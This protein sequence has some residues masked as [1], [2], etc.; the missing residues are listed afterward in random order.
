MSRT[1]VNWAVALGMIL[2]LLGLLAVSAHSARPI[3]AGPGQDIEAIQP[4][5]PPAERA[6]N[7]AEPGP[8][9]TLTH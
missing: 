8:G 6:L 9:V 5:L 1:L 4:E 3:A 7:P 2:A